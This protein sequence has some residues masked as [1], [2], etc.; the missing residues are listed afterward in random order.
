MS[1][2]LLYRA[3]GI[4]GYHYQRTNR[5]VGVRYV[6][7]GTWSA[8][9]STSGGSVRCR[10]AASR[11]IWSWTCPGRS[12]GS[13]RSVRQVKIG[14]ADPRVGYT[15]AFERYALELSKYMT[16]KDVAHHLGISWDVIKEIQKRHLRDS[17]PPLREDELCTRRHDF[18][19]QATSETAV[20]QAQAE[21]SEADRH[22]RDFHGQ[23]APV[24]DDRDGPGERRSGLR[25]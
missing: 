2:S 22:R 11:C 1:T 24:P 7:R 18:R 9:G 15:R 14:F 6:D 10:S 8:R 4:R 16:I 23:G 25:G 12:V 20:R 17:A 13:A 21:A 3:F 5:V 19:D